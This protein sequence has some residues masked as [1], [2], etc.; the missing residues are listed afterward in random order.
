MQIEA[1]ERPRPNTR[2]PDK[3]DRVTGPFIG[4]VV[5]VTVGVMTYLSAATLDRTGTLPAVTG[6][7]G[8]LVAIAN[9]LAT[10]LGLR[11]TVIGGAIAVAMQLVLIGHALRERRAPVGVGRPPVPFQPRTDVINAF[12]AVRRG[13]MAFGVVQLLSTLGIG[14]LAVAISTQAVV[15]PL[16]A[17]GFLGSCAVFIGTAIV[18]NRAWKCPACG[19][20]PGS[21][22]TTVCA[23]CGAP[24]E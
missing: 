23:S 17:V 19:G 14:G 1:T 8:Y 10:I 21:R 15:A 11:G 7:G 24:L 2:P 20:F 16:E 18:G 3:L 9:A 12:A 13:R 6:R 22:L 5:I 4:L